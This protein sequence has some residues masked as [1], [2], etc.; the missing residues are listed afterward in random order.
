MNEESCKCSNWCLC[1][2]VVFNYNALQTVIVVV[3]IRAQIAGERIEPSE[4]WRVLLLEE[5]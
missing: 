5:S 1:M 4:E 2:R 3:N